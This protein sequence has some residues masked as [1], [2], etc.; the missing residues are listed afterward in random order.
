[1]RQEATTEGM[2]KDRIE[3]VQGLILW[4]P[5]PGERSGIS[6]ETEKERPEQEEEDEDTEETQLE[7]V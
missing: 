4:H 3:E 6:K 5:K 7:S 2:N 1:M